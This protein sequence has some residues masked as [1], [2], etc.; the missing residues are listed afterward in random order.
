[1]RREVGPERGRVVPQVALEI[2]LGQGESE[3]KRLVL[4]ADGALAQK[5]ET[6]ERATQTQ[7]ATGKRP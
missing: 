7:V 3:R 2:L 4:N 5:L 6:Y 1:M